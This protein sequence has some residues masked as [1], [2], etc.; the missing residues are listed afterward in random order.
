MSNLFAKAPQP[1]SKEDFRMAVEIWNSKGHDN[2]VGVEFD[3]ETGEV[4]LIVP[5][6]VMPDL[7]Y[8]IRAKPWE[9]DSEESL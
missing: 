2:V 3:E 6:Y 4:I 1:V 5:D 9:Y 7:S 8:F